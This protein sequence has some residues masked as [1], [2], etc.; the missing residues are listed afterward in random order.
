[1]AAVCEE[2]QI[3]L[4]C[5]T[6]MKLLQLSGKPVHTYILFSCN[7]CRQHLLELDSLVAHFGGAC[8]LSTLGRICFAHPGLE[9]GS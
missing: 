2:N 3:V 6:A 9:T 8:G 1:M 7:C 5:H 4:S